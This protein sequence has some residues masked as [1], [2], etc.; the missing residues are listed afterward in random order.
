MLE[1]I[2]QEQASAFKK[3][4]PKII[5]IS[6]EHIY[7]IVA[8]VSTLCQVKDIKSHLCIICRTPKYTI[9]LAV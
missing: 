2:V 1:L 9:S 7:P 5:S 6:M 3:L 4:L 8:P